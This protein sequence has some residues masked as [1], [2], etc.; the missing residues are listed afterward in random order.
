[1]KAQGGANARARVIGPAVERAFDLPLMTR[2]CVGPAWT[3][4]S[5]AAEQA[6]VVNGLAMTIAQYAAN[7]DSY[8]GEQ[9][10]VTGPVD[11]RGGDKLVRTMLTGKSANEMIAYRLRN[12][13]RGN[14]ALSMCSIAFD[15][16]ACHAPVGFSTVVARGGAQALVAHL[17]R[18]AADPK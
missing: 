13:A 8:S 11:S 1:M 2:L 5:A 18:L 9:I 6:G 16:P 15:Q 10:A 17:N 12:R 3:S 4:F 14:G 7:F